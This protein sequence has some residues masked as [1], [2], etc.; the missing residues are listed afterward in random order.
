MSRKWQQSKR[1]DDEHLSAPALRPVKWLLRAFSSIRLSV[2]LLT[3]V[4]LYGV[5]ASVPIGMLALIPTWAFYSAT[6]AL[7][8]AVAGV[9]V[10]AL[11]RR[12]VP[13]ERAVARLGGSIIAAAVAVVAISAV[14][15]HAV[16]PAIHFDPADGSGARFF[17]DFVRTNEAITLRRLPGFEMTELEFYS[18]WPLHAV[19]LAFV[20]NMVTATVRRIAFTFKNLGV[21]TVHTGIVII[22]LGSVYYQGLKKEGDT[23]VFAG[24]PGPDGDPA[25]GTTQTGFYDNTSVALWL[26]Q[27]TTWAG[28]PDW[29]QRP[30]RGLPRYNDYA[31]DAGGAGDA[32]RLAETLSVDTPEP[33][34][35]A[36]GRDL[37]IDVPAGSSQRIDGDIRVRIVGYAS[38]AEPREDWAKSDPPAL[39]DARPVRVIE[40]LSRLPDAPGGTPRDEGVAVLRAPLH[41]TVPSHRIAENDAFVIEHTIAA[42]ANRVGDL[43]TPVPERT[44]HALIIDVPGDPSGAGVPTRTVVSAE[45]GNEYVIGNT[46]WR[47]GV[48]QLLPE[49]PFP[50]ITAGYEDA[51]SPTAVVRIS[52]PDTGDADAQAYDRYV[53]DR[54]PELNQDVF[55][56]PRAGPSGG[57]RPNRRAADPA[58]RVAYLDLTRLRVLLNEDAETGLVRTIVRQP[59]GRIN[60]IEPTAHGDV[61]ADMVPMLDLRVAEAWAHAERIEFP[62]PVPEPER[63]RRFVGTHDLAMAA[64]ELSAPETLPGWSSVVWLPFARYLETSNDLVRTATLPDGRELTLA[65]GRRRHPFPGFGVRLLDFEMIAYDHRGAPRDYQS[66][67]RVVPQPDPRDPDGRSPIGEAYERVAKLNA[68]LRAPFVWDETR[69]AFSNAALMLTRGLNPNQYKLSQAGWD[70]QGWQRTQALADEGQLARPFARFTI[71][72]VGNNPGIHVIAFGGVLMSLGIPWAFYVKPWLVRREKARLAERS[73]AAKAAPAEVVEREAVP[74]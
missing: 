16:W 65:F 17:A 9:A 54:F 22:A 71:L 15:A 68:P 64:V 26:A 67:L 8:A 39:D 62:V 46:G 12:L 19:L 13:P 31:L 63:E 41:P 20:A 69:A 34:A 66:V 55:D 11:V 51:T 53:Y 47:V 27:R 70:Q 35:D 52:P 59:G 49:P 3:F 57:G 58:I 28:T 21:L 38:Y 48:K 40:V 18:W 14:W 5:L 61:I 10:V 32:P 6:V 72:Q 44:A 23:I 43:L 36:P 30:L 45:V 33:A 56:T 24:A 1:W 29:E 37:A 25:I 2:V 4:A 42:S 7:P 73:A 50:I 74:A 60:V